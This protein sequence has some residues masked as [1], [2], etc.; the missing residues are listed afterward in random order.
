[1]KIAVITPT[2]SSRSKLL[3][4]CK[5]SVRNQTTNIYIF[6]SYGEDTDRVG[7]GQMRNKLISQLD[8][9]YDWIA[10]LDDDDVMLSN[11]L[12]LLSQYCDTADIIYSDCETV[13]W[14]KS[15]ETSAFNKDRL[16]QRNYIPVT[17]LMRRST[18]ESMNGFAHIF[19]EDWDLWKRCSIAG[20]RFAF[21]PQV[22]WQYRRFGESMLTTGQITF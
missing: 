18:F 10:F 9:S 8:S 5:Q 20:A 22:T 7:C 1:M 21:V 4:E 2:I 15:W 6:H 11:H 19:A 3:S 14:F 17:V 13:G 16:F 12:E